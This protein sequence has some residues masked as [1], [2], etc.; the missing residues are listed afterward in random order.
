MRTA[1][2]P[3]AAWR[4]RLQ[5]VTVDGIRTWVLNEGLGDPVV[6]LHGIPTSSFVWRDVA[7]VI[8]R[9]RRAVAPD[10]IGFG[11]ADRP[12][13]ADLSPAGQAES[14]LRVLDAIGVDKAALVGHDYGALV[15]CE[16]L[17]RAPERVSHIVVTNTSVWIDD[18][19]GSPL[20]PLRLINL[21][22]AGRLL[23]A[24]ARPF[25][26]R[27]AFQWYVDED[28]R[29]TDDVMAVYWHPFDDGFWDVLR[30]LDEVDGMTSTDF[31]RW[32]EALYNFQGPGLVAW[33]AN[34]RT[35]PPSRAV[36]IGK[37]LH[38]S[39]TDIFEHANHFIQE[40]RPDALG[41]LILAFLSGALMR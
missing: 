37:L 11:L 14:M 26:L 17:A 33:G 9:E 8:A 34:D 36:E 24:V 31:H 21:P 25:M 10:L 12:A 29:L 40:D 18:W 22:V 20:S 30:R 41:R 16:I 23:T 27:Q 3:V 15:A 2:D 6:L 28:E 5:P 39:R 32:R 13:G 38:D 4:A 7:R 1:L 19:R 35:F